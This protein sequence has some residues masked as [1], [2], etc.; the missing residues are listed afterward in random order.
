MTTILTKEFGRTKK[1]RAVTAFELVNGSG[2]RVRILDYGAAIQRII[3]PDRDGVPTDVTLGYDDLASY[4]AGSCFYG[5]IV[6]RYANRI[7]DSGRFVLDGK[8]IRL[9]KNSEET[10]HVHG[11]YAKRMFEASIDGETL[12]MRYLSPDGEE[13]FPGSLSLEVRYRLGEDNALE[14]C[15]A[16][17][18]DAPTC[19]TPSPRSSRRAWPRNDTACFVVH[20]KVDGHAGGR[21]D[22]PADLVH[23]GGRQYA[24]ADPRKQGQSHACERSSGGNPGGRYRAV[25]GA[26]QGWRILPAPGVETGRRPGADLRRRQ[27]KAGRLVPAFAYTRQT[28]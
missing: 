16:A 8:E 18:T 10:N 14:L 20:R 11:V 19:R 23:R 22:S 7:G 28:V 13:G 24:P 12:V 17:T 3:V 6:G 9:E 4:E 25:S 5:A 15:Y 1:G 26:L 2:M 27:P 21:R